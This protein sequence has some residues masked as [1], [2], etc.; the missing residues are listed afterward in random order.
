MRELFSLLWRL[1]TCHLTGGS[2]AGLAVDEL[3]QEVGV[4]AVA[5]V[6]L[7]H[8]GGRSSAGREARCPAPR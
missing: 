5:G 7:D 3:A 1:W 6:L 4:A 8:V 2:V